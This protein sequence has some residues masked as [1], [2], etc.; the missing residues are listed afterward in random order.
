MAEQ[1]AAWQHKKIM[2]ENLFGVAQ[3]SIDLMVVSFMLWLYMMVSFISCWLVG[4][5]HYHGFK[6]W[7]GFLHLFF[8]WI[9]S[10]DVGLIDR[11]LAYA[12]PLTVRFT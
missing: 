8:G 6:L 5:H 2:C 11:T 10:V 3:L 9:F 12:C 1:P 4:F 7:C